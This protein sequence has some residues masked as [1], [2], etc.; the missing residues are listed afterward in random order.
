[1]LERGRKRPSVLVMGLKPQST[2][3]G[4]G[5]RLT[6]S[7]CEIE[8]ALSRAATTSGSAKPL[9]ALSAETRVT[10]ISSSSCLR[11]RVSGNPSNRVK[12]SAQLRDRLMQG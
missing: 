12:T 2:E 11:S 4:A 9:P 3:N 8:F 7:R 5:S 6:R 1:M 10:W